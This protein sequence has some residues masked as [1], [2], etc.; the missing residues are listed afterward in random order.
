MQKEDISLIV[1][2]FFE[3][4]YS[5]GQVETAR[6]I[7]SQDFVFYGPAAGVHG[8]ENFIEFSQG[9][10]EAL[11]ITFR[12]EVL[13]IDIDVGKVATYSRMGVTHRGQF[14]GIEPTG[15][16]FEL[17]R[18]DNFKFKDDKLS[19]VN[20]IMDHQLLMSRLKQEKALMSE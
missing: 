5:Q 3:D 6:Q 19:E 13:I 16:Q 7:L 9:I 4:V 1:Q 8:P 2:R 14:R 20:T 11:A 17:P 15:Q 18:I 10:R 12:I